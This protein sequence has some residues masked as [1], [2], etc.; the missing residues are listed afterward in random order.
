MVF[1]GT[2]RCFDGEAQR[3][4]P[5]GGIVDHAAPQCSFGSA[6]AA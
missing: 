5:D 3:H 2:S 6:D 4:T 1:R